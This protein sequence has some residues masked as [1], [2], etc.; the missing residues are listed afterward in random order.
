MMTGEELRT[1]PKEDFLQRM[2]G[3]IIQ[4]VFMMTYNNQVIV[5]SQ[6]LYDKLWSVGWILT[7]SRSGFNG[8]KYT[9]ILSEPRLCWADD[10]LIDDMFKVKIDGTMP[11]GAITLE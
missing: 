5:V 11:V 6:P 7:I 3:A 2:R 9:S 4:A 8:A 10:Q 1:M